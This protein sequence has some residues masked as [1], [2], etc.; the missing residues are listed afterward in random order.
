MTLPLPRR[1]KR[2]FRRLAKRPVL[3]LCRSRAKCRE[4]G[5][6]YRKTCADCRRARWHRR[7]RERCD[8]H[9][10]NWSRSCARCRRALR[11]RRIR[12]GRKI[13]R[14][15]GLQLGMESLKGAGHGIAAFIL[16]AWLLASNDESLHW[17]IVVAAIAAAVLFDPVVTGTR[18]VKKWFRTGSYRTDDTDAL[19]E[20]DWQTS[21]ER[22]Q[23]KT[24]YLKR[25]R[26][27]GAAIGATL[28]TI[29][30]STL[31]AIAPLSA[32]L[33]AYEFFER[34]KDFYDNHPLVTV[35]AII[36]ISLLPVP[37]AMMGHSAEKALWPKPDENPM[38]RDDW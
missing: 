38:R 18:L 23:R 12:L 14:G 19:W 4:H 10:L 3:H 31:L 15:V 16:I 33:T 13:T 37:W 7:S 20:A 25:R 5:T 24:Q 29:F 35:I 36:V 27:K 21:R 11:R 26:W 28:G 22:R 1:L 34:S 8:V 6:I 2:L 9:G 17:Q 32:G 30:V